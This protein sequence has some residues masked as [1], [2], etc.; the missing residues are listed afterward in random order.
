[1]KKHRHW[2]DRLTDELDLTG[3]VNLQSLVELAGDRRVLIENYGGI[4]KYQ[5]DCICVKVKFGTVSVT[6]RALTIG[7]MDK[8]QLV[9]NGR[10]DC[11]TLKRGNG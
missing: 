10:I 9:I 5:P 6:G 4:Q 3:E 1:M 11:V 8:N 2:M 7:R